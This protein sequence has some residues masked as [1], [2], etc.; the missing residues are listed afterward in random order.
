MPYFFGIFEQTPHAPTALVLFLF[1]FLGLLVHN[2]LFKSELSFKHPIIKPMILFSIFILVSGIITFFRYA[3]FYPFLSDY[4]Y[5][6]ITNV[7]GVTAG[8]AIMSLFFSSLNYLTGFAF[9]LVLLNLVKSEEFIKKILI[10]LL[11]STFFSLIFGFYQHFND[12]NVGNT[13]VRV[14]SSTVNA[15]FKDPNSFG[16]YLAVI[17][18]ILFGMILAFKKMIKILPIIAIIAAF[19][20][21]PFTGSLSGLLGMSIS[22]L[23]FL[24]KV[25]ISI[26]FT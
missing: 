7:N 15:T 20:I 10:V 23:F 25:N 6:L 16:V 8:G 21:L 17:I 22:F 12:I 11:I 19:F 24:F 3:N 9:L 18:P 14:K 5:E 13:P 4:I 1:Y 26:L 2:T